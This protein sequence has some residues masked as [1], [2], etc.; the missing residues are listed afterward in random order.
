MSS[1]RLLSN[2]VRRQFIVLRFSDV[3]IDD[4]QLE[5]THIPFNEINTTWLR[6]MCRQLKP[7]ETNYKRLKFIKGGI[8]LNSNSD[9]KLPDFFGDEYNSKLY[10]HCMIGQSLT[11][12]ELKNEDKLDDMRDQPGATTIQAI[13]FDRLRGVGFSDDEIELLREQFRST[14]GDLNLLEM[15]TNDNRDIRQLEERWMETG[16]NDQQNEFNSVPSANFRNN[17]DLLIG[18][19][20]GFVLGGFT[21]LLIKQEGLFNKRQKMAI[22][23]GILFNITFGIRNF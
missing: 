23:V 13:G 21:I 17:K 1:E 9:L 10:I 16:V 8:M 11:N 15:E 6:K 2:S 22:F 12:D 4:L 20:I 7:R 5:I 14:Y 18:L 3:N 19:T